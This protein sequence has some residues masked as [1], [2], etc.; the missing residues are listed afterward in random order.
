VYWWEKRKKWMVHATH[1]GK[2]HN[3][4]YFDELDKA[5]AKAVELRNSLYTHNDID[6]VG[7]A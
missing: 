7:A 6:R 1:N 5:E 2:F 4:G 3:G